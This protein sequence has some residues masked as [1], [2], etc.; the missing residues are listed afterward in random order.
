[1]EQ[2]EDRQ[3]M[4]GDM[5]A[6]IAADGL[7]RDTLYVKEA[8]GQAGRGNSVF[9]RQMGQDTIRVLGSVNADGSISL[10]NGKQYEDFKIAKMPGKVN[11]MR[12]II[13]DVNLGRGNDTVNVTEIS[14]YGA[15]FFASQNYT[16]TFFVTDISINV[17]DTSS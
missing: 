13:L 8:T 9:I 6:Y 2:L 5:S 17:G 15:T 14:R 7:G 3:M 16:P 10:V 11:D 4:A 1:M 12:P